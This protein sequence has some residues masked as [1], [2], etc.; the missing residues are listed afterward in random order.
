MLL[1]SYGRQ[2]GQKAWDRRPEDFTHPNLLEWV[3][4]SRG[5]L[6]GA[7]LTL[8]RHWHSVGK[9]RWIGRPPGSFEGWART[10]GGILETAGI[11]GF[12]GNTKEMLDKT[13]E[14]T[15][16]WETFLTTW[17]NAFGE[18][19]LTAKDLV[20]RLHEDEFDAVRETLPAQLATHYIDGSTML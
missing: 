14:G 15:G 3:S 10:V 12:L 1:D 19:K 6:L 20:E 9:P 13:T 5:D 8:A 11:P 18:A 17:H 2:D 7:L 16:E 4:E